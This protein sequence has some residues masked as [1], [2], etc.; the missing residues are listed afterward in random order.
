MTGN[1]RVVL[2]CR[3]QPKS[4]CSVTISGTEEEVLELGEYHATTKHG[5]A[6]KPELRQQL[7]SFLK[8]ESLIV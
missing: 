1:K 8:Q 6:K 5:I 7:R 3:N 2:D 4:N